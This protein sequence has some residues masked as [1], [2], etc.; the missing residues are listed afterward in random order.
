MDIFGRVLSFI[1][2]FVYRFFRLSF[3]ED[4]AENNVGCRNWRALI[5]FSSLAPVS[6]LLPLISDPRPPIFDSRPPIENDR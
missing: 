2:F 3:M 5:I 6:Y 1:V 4:S